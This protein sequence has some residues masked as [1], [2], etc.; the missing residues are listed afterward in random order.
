MS[1][2]VPSA[3]GPPPKQPRFR[4]DNRFLA[5]ILITC[6]LVVGWWKFGITEDNSTPLLSKL[7]SCWISTYSPTF[8]SILVAIGLEIILGKWMTGKWPHLASAY[9]SGISVGILVRST[10]LWPYILCSL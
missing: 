3:K 5:P 7:T 4:F 2:P 9:I 8:V 6:I 1:A 10:E